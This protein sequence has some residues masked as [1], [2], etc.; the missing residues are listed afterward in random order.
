MK[1]RDDMNDEEIKQEID[2][3]QRSRNCLVVGMVVCVAVI[4]LAQTF[5]LVYKMGWLA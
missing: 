5:K 4:I 3:L 2:R 1:G